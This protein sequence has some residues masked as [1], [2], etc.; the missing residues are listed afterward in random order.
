MPGGHAPIKRGN[1]HLGGIISLVIL[2]KNSI[3]GIKSGGLFSNIRKPA[4]QDKTG[5]RLLVHSL[6]R[7]Q[8]IR[9]INQNLTEDIIAL[10]RCIAR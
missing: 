4:R 9:K 10:G 5:Y 6:N 2:L 7:I 3:N 8:E 1:G